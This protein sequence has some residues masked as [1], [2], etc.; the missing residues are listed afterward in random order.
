MCRAL[1][2]LLAAAAVACGGKSSRP[3]AAGQ[4]ARV[5]RVVD[6]DTVVLADGR[7]VRYL[8]INSPELDEPLGRAARAENRR[9]TE[10]REVVLSFDGDRHDGYGRLLAYVTAGRV[11]VN[12]RLLEQGL[13]HLFLFG[14]LSREAELYAAQEKARAT[15]R[16]LWEDRR[17]PG[18]LHITAVHADPPGDDRRNLN[19]EVVVICNVSPR[20]VDLS[21]YVLENHAGRRLGLPPARLEPGRVALVMS[22]RGRDRLVGP[23]PLIIHWRAR[24]PVWRNAG[25]VAVLRGPAGRLIERH[26][27]RPK[28]HWH[29]RRRWK[30]RRSGRHG[31]AVAPDR[32]RVRAGS[33]VRHFPRTAAR[34]KP[35]ALSRP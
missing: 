2:Y 16:G 12:R 24:L 14:H 35:L 21:G 15:G 9:L 7:I 1:A 33:R 6:G 10:G 11:F 3:A 34:S 4:R 30:P 31:N 19:G 5:A 27:V 18:P 29:R 26:E 28:R 25:D 23:A 22:G 32:A 20:A 13:A 8:G 17:L